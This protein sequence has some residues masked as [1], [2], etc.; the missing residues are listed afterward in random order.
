MSF[1]T[2]RFTQKSYEAIA[3]A[4]AAAERLGNAEV[5]PEH[6]LYALLD[7]SD[8]V[9]P[10]VLSKLNLPVGALKQQVN[11]EI[12]RFPR[13]S[14]GGVQVQLGSRLRTVL[15]KAH[16]ELAQFG[17]EYVSTEHLLL[18][19]LDHAGGGAERVLKQAGLT[20]D[21]LLMALRE[22]RGAQRVTSPNPEST[23]AALEQYGRDLTELA[24]RNK[25]DPVIG[26]DEEIRRVI[27]ILSRRTKNNPVLIG[28]PGVGKT[29]IVE[30]LAQRI[31][32]GDVPEA[33]KNKRVIALDMGALIAGAKYRG[34]F[35]ERLKAVLKEIQERDDI[36]LFVDELH[37]VVGAGAAEGAMDAGNMLKPMLARGELHMVGATTLDEYRKHIEKDAALERRF[38]PVMVDPPSVE[39]TISIL[40][41]LKERYETH[42]GV[43]ITDGALIAAAMLSDRY[44]S[45]RFL[46]DKAIDLIDEAAA[47]LR[48]EITSDPQELDDLKR[49]IMQLEIE[50]EALRKEKDQASKERL[51]KLE[52]ELANLR[53]QRSALE[54]QIQRE[55]QE[56]ERIQQIKEKI[57]QTRA[58][59]EQAQRQYDYNKAAE[60]QYGT[61]VGL[62]RELQAAE[63]QL[64]NQSRLLRQ[65]V[66]ETDIAEIVSKW[67]GIPVTKLLEGELEK[68]VHMEER[69]HQR[70]VGQ[71]E[72]VTAVS[73][74]IRRARA[75]LQDPNRP[76]GS[77]LFLGPT[78]VGKTELARALAEFLFDDEQAMIRIDMSEYME[79]HSVARLI[80]AP[81]GY[82]GYDEGGQL[83]E[84]VR[85]KPYSVV[86]FDEIEKA[87]PDVFNV[88]LQV[89]DDGRLTDGQG[90]V[91]N[92]KNTVIIMTSNI[93]SATIQE[94]TRAGAGQSEIRA[95]V[96]EELRSVL[97]PEFL[98]RIDEVIVFSPLSREHIDQIVEIQINRLRKLLADRKL[99]L[100]L[101]DA[102]RAQLAAEGYDPVYGARPL[103][104]VIQQRIQNPLALQLLQGNFPEGSTI[105]VDVERG[106]FAFHRG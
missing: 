57:E 61:L 36:I 34:E 8:G 90:R 6:L 51:E 89:L 97:R 87:H 50:R 100:T 60:L 96:M 103:K 39:D 4:Q 25:L 18:A 101:T 48:M 93:A 20:R 45:D 54:A 31:V 86:L 88:L 1:N 85:R 35:E 70:V 44:I 40:R 75:G 2:N 46:P 91:V 11:N 68:L 99:N 74:A 29:A 17:D 27:Q 59:I 106:N 7:Q 94:L 43:R 13:I 78:G 14:G 21:K 52:Q 49:R 28:E 23:Y 56:L 84:A 104:R 63:A 95:A 3:A 33:L 16:D 19:I 83:T 41:G 37:T 26:R 47:R 22:V 30:G 64:G 55:R 32:R 53:E 10:Q 76:L 42:H 67:T 66:T 24:A 71:D 102:A 5:Q 80:G 58:A 77:F 69:L 62:E 79:K 15:V 12:S 73:N 65:E 38:Q 105:V 81:P 9:V 82:V 92:F 72:A 98:N